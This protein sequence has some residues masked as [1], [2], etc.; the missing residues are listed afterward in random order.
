MTKINREDVIKYKQIR[1]NQKC[2]PRTQSNGNKKELKT[3]KPATINRELAVLKIFFNYCITDKK[4]LL[5][6]P[7]SKVKFFDE[8]N[9]QTRVVSQEEERLY[10]MA[11]SQPLRDFASVMADTGMRP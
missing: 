4:I 1:S 11:A 2:R 7:V 9:G 5:S 3:L 6:N 10:L 8:N